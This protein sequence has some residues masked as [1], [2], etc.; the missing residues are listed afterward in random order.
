VFQFAVISIFSFDENSFNSEA[1]PPGLRLRRPVAGRKRARRPRVPAHKETDGGGLQM[2]KIGL[3]AAVMGLLF[4]AAPT[5]AFAGGNPGG[6]ANKMANT[7]HCKSGKVAR[8]A[9]A[10][11]ENGGHL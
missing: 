7:Y 9:K 2:Q 4:A 5:L 6:N 8:H 10:C 3:V 1:S 11:K